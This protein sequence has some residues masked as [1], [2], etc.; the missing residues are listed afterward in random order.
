V[1]GGSGAH[2][3]G[4]P[5]KQKTDRN[6]ARLLLQL[7]EENRFPRIWFRTGPRAICASC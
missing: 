6:D 4:A 1:G 3:Q 5:R 7:L 2:P